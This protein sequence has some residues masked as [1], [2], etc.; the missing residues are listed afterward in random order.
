MMVDGFPMVLHERIEGGLTIRAEVP[1]M[2]I[3]GVIALLCVEHAGE[4][5]VLTTEK[6]LSDKQV[7]DQFVDVAVANLTVL[8]ESKEPIS[9]DW[10]T[11][12]FKYT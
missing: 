4:R 5:T 12:L 1:V 3:D 10:V 11:S 2:E 6:D 7:F 8:K 9:R